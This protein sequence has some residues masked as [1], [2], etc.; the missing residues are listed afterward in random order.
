MMGLGV[1]EIVLILALL[2]LLFGAKRIPQIARGLGEGIR[3]FR[4]SIKEGADD[5]DRLEDGSEDT[6]RLKNGSD[7]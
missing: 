1:G 7:R 2:V 4:T 6:G 3:N 5:P